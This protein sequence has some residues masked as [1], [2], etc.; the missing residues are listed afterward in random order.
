MWAAL[1]LWA[2][3]HSAASRRLWFQIM[4]IGL[5]SGLLFLLQP[6]WSPSDMVQHLANAVLHDQ[7][8]AW[9]GT[10]RYLI[11]LALLTG[12]LVAAWLGHSFSVKPLALKLILMHLLAGTAM[13]AGASMVMGGND[14]QL[15]L[16]L[17]AASPAAL[18]TVASMLAGIYLGLR[19]RQPL[20][21]LRRRLGAD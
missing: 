14:L 15:L 10:E 8:N 13:G 21:L 4:V 11:V 18:V 9:P 7:V 19:L 20:H 6:F 12:M 1:T 3:K 17:P 5:L 2:L 16:A